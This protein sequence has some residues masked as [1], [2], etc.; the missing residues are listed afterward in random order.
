MM[1]A[2][3]KVLYSIGGGLL[4][5][6]VIGVF[7]PSRVQIERAATIDAHAATVFMLV[8]DFSQI[9][10]WSPWL[11]ADPNARI[12]LAGPRSGVGATISWD[13][14]ILGS[15]TRT[16]VESTPFERV[17]IAVELGDRGQATSTFSISEAD[18]RAIVTWRFETAFGINLVKRYV[19]LMLDGIVGREYEA[20]LAGLKEMA[21]SLPRADFSDIEIE[22]VVVDAVDIAYQ[23]T[24]S[25]PE[26]T[27]ISEAMGRAYFDVLAFMDEHD[28]QDAGPPLSIS[29]AFNGAQMQFDAGIPVR[30][31]RPETPRNAVGVRIGRTYAGPVI[32]V[33]HVGPYRTLGATHD[34]IAAYLA[35]SGLV[36]NGDAW[37]AYISDPTRTPESELLTYVY[38]PLV[39]GQQTPMGR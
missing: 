29:R 16:I 22:H 19:G 11:D 8:N 1:S 21:E 7:L 31:I 2:M 37:E 30:G 25:A 26:P 39:A 13:G 6:I 27:A 24:R 17:V 5:I 33:R 34:K 18:S 3:K 20:G 15:G 23:P 38:Y 35:A 28:L 32:R 14:N 9:N 36:R 4:A 10:K 12:E